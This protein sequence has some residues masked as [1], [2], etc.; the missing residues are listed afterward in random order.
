MIFKKKQLFF[1]KCL[2]LKLDIKNK[3]LLKLKSQLIKNIFKIIW[4][5]KIKILNIYLYM[6]DQKCFFSSYV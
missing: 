4:L 1:L 5:I 6:W 3:K 2:L